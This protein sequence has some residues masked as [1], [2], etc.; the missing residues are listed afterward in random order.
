MKSVLRKIRRFFKNKFRVLNVPV[1]KKGNITEWSEDF[2][3]ACMHLYHE[4]VALGG[5]FGGAAASLNFHGDEL[6]LNWEEEA[7]SV[8]QTFQVLL[9][10]A[11]DLPELCADD[12]VRCEI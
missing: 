10:N 4:D 2:K 3:A 5:N 1:P 12:D 7:S 8:Y 6:P 9:D 11:Q